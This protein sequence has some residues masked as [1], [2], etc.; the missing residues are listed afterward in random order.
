[1]IVCSRRVFLN[2]LT[3]LMDLDTLLNANYYL[4]DQI[5][6]NGGH[7]GFIDEPRLNQNG[8]L[9]FGTSLD[10]SMVKPA[11]HSYFIKYDNVL[12]MASYFSIAAASL[13]NDYSTPEEKFV[14][15]LQSTDTQYRIYQ[16]LFQDTLMGNGL[17]ILILRNDAGVERF[18]HIICS[19]LAQMF[20]ADI[21]FVDP[22]YR[23]KTH[24][25]L[26]YTGDKVFADQHIR[27]LRD[28][29]LLEHIQGMVNMAKYGDGLN[30]LTQFLNNP[31][32]GFDEIVHIYNLLFPGDPLKPGNYTIAHIKQIIIGR[33]MD[34]TG[35]RQE[36]S[37]LRNL[38]VGSFYAFSQMVDDA[39]E[40]LVG[41]EESFDDI[42]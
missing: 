16:F 12:D 25:Q 8:E 37:E 7:A 36:E 1:M 13:K 5:K 41:D 26:Q 31:N 38:G 42:L 19:Y 29:M 39:Y 9:E 6:P 40:P 4:G 30:N 32:I 24:G 23:P 11:I 28:I 35:K 27:K 21:T 34:A 15:Y 18:G 20:G 17:Q 22:K 3:Q 10:F 2:V 14:S 33:I